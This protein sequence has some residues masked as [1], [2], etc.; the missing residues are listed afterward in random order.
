MR[1]DLCSGVCLPLVHFRV[2][3][4]FSSSSFGHGV[5]GDWEYSLIYMHLSVCQGILGELAETAKP[6]K[7]ELEKDRRQDKMEIPKNSLGWFWWSR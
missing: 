1:N 3:S 5:L 7:T 4:R 6:W 2:A